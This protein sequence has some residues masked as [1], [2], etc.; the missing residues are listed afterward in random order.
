MFQLNFTNPSGGVIT[1][2]TPP[3]VT[4]RAFER[5][6]VN[7]LFQPGPT[8]IRGP[9]NDYKKAKKKFNKKFY[10]LNNFKKLKF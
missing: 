9:T 8:V 1:A 10:F 5:G 6:G 3:V 4:S 7:G 2:I